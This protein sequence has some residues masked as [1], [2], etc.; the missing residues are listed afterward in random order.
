[1]NHFFLCVCSHVFIRSLV[2]KC[3]AVAISHCLPQ[4]TL[5]DVL[6]LFISERNVNQAT[7]PC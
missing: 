4:L 2:C 5:S 1:M 7:A 3:G 6:E